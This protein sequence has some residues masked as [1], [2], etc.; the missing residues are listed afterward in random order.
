MDNFNF[1]KN[2]HLTEEGHTSILKRFLSPRGTHGYKDTFLRLFLEKIGVSY[3]YE[4]KWHVT[5]KKSGERGILDLII[6]NDDLSTIVVIENKIRNAK[7]QPSQLYRY[8]RN[9]IYEPMLK[10]GKY[11]K[12]F[13]IS[14]EVNENKEITDHYKVIYLTTDGRKTIDKKSLK[15]P[16]S[17]N[18][19]YNDFPETLK[20]NFT[21]LSYKKDIKD[22]L[23]ECKK[24]VS[25]DESLRLYLILKQYIEWIESLK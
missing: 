19:K 15:R 16:K 8:W 20:F 10:S 5:S 22:W 11:S 1:F 12:K 6:F 4:K 13:L 18:G 9:E 25:R 2:L 23:T 17:S 7:D 21:Q 24:V 3:N 14:D